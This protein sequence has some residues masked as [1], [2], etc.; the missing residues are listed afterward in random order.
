MMAV[1]RQL[2]L[3][4]PEELAEEAAAFTDSREEA[5]KYVLDHS[6]LCLDFGDNE[7]IAEYSVSGL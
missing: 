6:E 1:T 4:V 2:T 5:V 7:Y 3:D